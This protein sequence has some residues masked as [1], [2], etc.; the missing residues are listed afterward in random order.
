M[1]TFTYRA[2]NTEGEIRGG[3]LIADSVEEVVEKLSRDGYV[4]TSVK[5]HDAKERSSAARPARIR[6]K[7]HAVFARQLASFLKAGVPILRA[8]QI[9]SEQTGNRYLK[10]VIGEIE[11]SIRKGRTLAEALGK[12]PDA[13][14]P[15]Y[16]AM[17]RA[18]EDSGTTEEALGRIAQYYTKRAEFIAKVRSALTYPIL[19]VVVGFFTILFVFTNVIPRL[20]PLFA[21]LNVQLPLPTRILLAISA[22]TK[23]YWFY[24][25][26]GIL[27]IGVFVANGLKNKPFRMQVSRLKL[28][29]PIFGDF[30]FKSEFSG[31]ARAMEMALH[32]GVPI[33]SAME[34]SLPIIREEALRQGLVE[35]KKE[36]EAGRFLGDILRESRIVTPFVYNL[37]KV[38][39]ES[40]RLEE[41]L[42][43][44]ARSFEDDC[45]ENIKALTTLIEPVMVLII[46]LIVAFIVSATLLPIFQLNIISL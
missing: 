1:K 15:F 36:L 33:I 5:E 30:V 29:A 19:I 17:V 45:E 42:G 3:I 18:G 8:L 10:G 7:E 24:A 38:G 41:E 28:K 6:F 26:L 23:A 20:M 40:G 14:T 44:I 21:D 27:L 31:F 16:I 11:D 25:L 43:N 32:S 46:G 12:Y 22:F 13:F 34:I 39:E 35:S 9:L 37:V 2:K 4:A